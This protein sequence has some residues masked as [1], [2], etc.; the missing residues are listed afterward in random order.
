MSNDQLQLPL[1]PMSCVIEPAEAVMTTLSLASTS[2]NVPLLAA[3]WDSSTV[4]E[5][6][7]AATVGASLT[8]LTVM[9]TVA[10][11][12]SPKVSSIW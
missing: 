11:S 12:V 4:T 6:T 7:A 9:V 10:V 1:L 3:V 8:P 5:A 2:A